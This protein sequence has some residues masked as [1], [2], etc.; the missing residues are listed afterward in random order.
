[1]FIVP[2]MREKPKPVT[3]TPAQLRRRWFWRIGLVGGLL[4]ALFFIHVP[5]KV[6]VPVTPDGVGAYQ[7]TIR[8]PGFTTGAIS[9]RTIAAGDVLTKLNNP[10]FAEERSML[11]KQL[12]GAE[13]TYETVQ[14]DDPVK[15][16]AARKQIESLTAQRSIMD[17][18]IA[19]L[20]QVTQQDG[21]FLQ[22]QTISAGTWLGAGDAVGIFLPSTGPV[23]LSGL[24]PER[25]VTL[26]QG[27]VEKLTL[28]SGYTYFD[29]D[30]ESA[31][32][33]E[34]LQFDRETGARSWQLN[35]AFPQHS[36]AKMA[37]VPADV[38][39]QFASAPLWR[40]VQFFGR[41]LLAKYREA[42]LLDR[43]GFLEK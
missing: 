36:P 40:H 2:A 9:S 30:P 33:R 31:T 39:V 8:S 18:Q 23:L 6:V 26:F 38:R 21:T 13:L 16:L 27:G 10:I 37:G 15:S 42:Q 20:Q 28:H 3:P 35:F 7:V 1:M 25:Y 34:V 32:I 17:R 29:L 19:G 11:S 43:R 4:F 12:E 5:F 14:G 24:F 22:T 41:S